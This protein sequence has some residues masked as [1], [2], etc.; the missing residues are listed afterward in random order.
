MIKKSI[1]IILL[2]LV[3]SSVIAQDIDSLLSSNITSRKV[4]GIALL[5]KEDNPETVVKKLKPL[6]ADKSIRVRLEVIK[7]LGNTKL[8]SAEPLLQYIKNNEK[9]KSVLIEVDKALEKIGPIPQ[10]VIQDRAQ[11]YS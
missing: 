11:K 1:L 7:T 4:A 5:V 10:A 8:Y 2:L 9:N 3:T 6:V